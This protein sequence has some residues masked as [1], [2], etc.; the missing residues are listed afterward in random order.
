M[1]TN[2]RVNAYGHVFVEG[3][4][5]M[6]VYLS[7]DD[8]IVGEKQSWEPPIW[9]CEIASCPT[10]VLERAQEDLY[11]DYYLMCQARSVLPRS[12]R[13]QI[14]LVCIDCDECGSGSSYPIHHPILVH[15]TR[16]EGTTCDVCGGRMS[17]KFRYGHDDWSS[18]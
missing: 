3:F 2:V 18:T 10:S 14:D 17:R 4:G 1:I 7:D 5:D 9:V 11:A 15:E 6:P 8:H 16:L 12:G 13:I